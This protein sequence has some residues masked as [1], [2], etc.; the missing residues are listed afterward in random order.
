M[1]I[2]PDTQNCSYV[3][4]SVD[5]DFQDVMETLNMVITDRGLVVS[6]TFDIAGML[7]RTEEVTGIKTSFNNAEVI[8]FC[9]AGLSSKMLSENPHRIIFCPYRIAVYTLYEEPSKVFLSYRPLACSGSS[10]I[11]FQIDSLVESLIRET[12]KFQDQY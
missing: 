12:I 1:L 7:K 6:H 2:K 10:P 3:R 8:E 5:G 11:L 4:F 9:S